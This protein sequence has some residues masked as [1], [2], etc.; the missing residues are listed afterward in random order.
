MRVI[1]RQNT[2]WNEPLPSDI[3]VL[4]ERWR[5]QLSAYIEYAFP[6]LYFGNGKPEDLASQK[7]LTILRLELQAAVLGVRLMQTVREAHSAV[8]NSCFLWSDW[9]TV[10]KWIRSEHRPQDEISS[11]K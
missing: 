4:W 2:C 3:A 1:W 11:H 8:V 7:A 9:T 10:L 6:R 5:K